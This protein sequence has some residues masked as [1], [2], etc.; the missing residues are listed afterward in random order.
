[1]ETQMSGTHQTTYNAV[2]Q[3]PIARNIQ[4]HDMRSMLSA[5]ADVTSEHNGN[6]KFT[7]NGER[8]PKPLFKAELF[9]DRHDATDAICHDRSCNVDD[10]CD[11]NRDW[12][13]HGHDYSYDRHHDDSHHNDDP[14]STLDE[15]QHSSFGER[16]KIELAPRRTAKVARVKR[17][18]LLSWKNL[19]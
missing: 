15:I 5:L 4:W 11:F 12:S 16:A 6:L 7:R 17:F 2:F 10:N 3:H 13:Y 19:C 14:Y 9:S 8:S 18:M 1:M